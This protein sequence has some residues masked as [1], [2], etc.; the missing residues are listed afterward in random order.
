MWS[1][2]CLTLAV[3][4]CLLLV[5]HAYAFGE[6]LSV[7]Q[8]FSCFAGRAEGQLIRST[9]FCPMT[10]QLDNVFSFLICK[11]ERISS[12]VLGQMY[13][14][15]I[16]ELT[17][18]VRAVLAL[19]TVIFGISF[20]IGLIP[21]TGRD[22]LIFI[23]KFAFVFG[24]ATN[25]DLLIDIGY[26]FILAGMR[27]GVQVTLQ[28]T[29][30]DD[31]DMQGKN[32]YQLIDG[33]LAEM[34]RNVSLTSIP[35]T[36]PAV[37]DARCQ[38]AVF[39]ALAVLGAVFPI[40][41]FF[42]LMLIARLVMCFFRAVFAYIYAMVG[43]T[44][45]IILAPIF[46][47]FYL[48]KVTQSFFDKWI[49]YLAGFMIQVVLLFAALGFLV[50]LDV[51][52]FMRDL[53]NIIMYQAET[54]E[55]SSFRFPWQYCTLCDFRLIHEGTG[56]DMLEGNT[57]HTMSQSMI[58][59]GRL[60]C[61]ISDVN[62]PL[63]GYSY[64]EKKPATDQYG[65]TPIN[66]LYMLSP[67]TS[68]GQMNALFA[69][70]ISGLLALFLLALAVERLLAYIPDLAQL[71]A[72]SMG[73]GAYAPELGSQALPGQSALDRFEAGF[74][75]G[76]S[77][78]ESSRFDPGKGVPIFGNTANVASQGFKEGLSR[79][80]TGGST[81]ARAED[82]KKVKEGKI[83]DSDRRFT[84]T[85]QFNNTVLDFFRNPHRDRE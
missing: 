16:T 72:R 52:T 4:G 49:G 2:T 70:A 51:K 15:L 36:S 8:S 6:D 24:F 46:L 42:A 76:V 74:K 53:P 54:L 83:K 60:Q 77:K 21:I 3:L 81:S 39:A 61:K 58:R 30:G 50:S 12:E 43:S 17:P 48:F 59:E 34:L 9:D 66:V 14:G 20:T 63:D 67:K 23:I 29:L 44:F 47:P 79:M 64:D 11:F 32:V 78:D 28:S 55:S 82:D 84:A 62:V 71:M 37:A 57:T 56:E 10:L 40:L 25:A 38:G 35:T 13:C 19:A 18:A 69:I 27:D 1:I 33:F 75:E 85:K 65:R 22:A 5:P 68:S 26:N 80:V 31:P 41:G 73:A 7:G 45:L